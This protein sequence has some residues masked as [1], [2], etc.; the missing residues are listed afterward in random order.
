MEQRNHAIPLLREYG[1]YKQRSNSTQAKAQRHGDECNV[2]ERNQEALAQSAEVVT[3]L[4]VGRK[5]NA[6]GDPAQADDQQVGDHE[7]L[8]IDGK[9][10]RSHHFADDNIINVGVQHRHG[11]HGNDL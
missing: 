4:G 2:A 6:R 1:A 3:K 8:P 7:C 10:G 11:F 5:Q 9:V